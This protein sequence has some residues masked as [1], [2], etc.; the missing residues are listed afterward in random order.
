MV[1]IRSLSS[2]EVEAA[3][4]V[5]QYSVGLG[6]VRLA[7]DTGLGGRPWCSPPGWGGSGFFQ[8]HVGQE[9][10]DSDLSEWGTFIHELTHVWQGQHNIPFWYMISSGC[11]QAVSTLSTGSHGSAY[12]VGEETQWYNY[13]SEQQGTIVAGWFHAGLSPWDWRFRYISTNI[14]PGQ[15]FAA[16]VPV[17]PR[18]TRIQ[19]YSSIL[20]NIN[21]SRKI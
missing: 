2:A 17:A 12:S 3:N 6:M 11:S 8:L 9:A 16:S 7:S 19:D 10:F 15:P 18:F 20:G 14:R 1:Q 5:F 21:F 13:N 4:S